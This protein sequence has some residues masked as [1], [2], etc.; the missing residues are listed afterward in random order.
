MPGSG[1]HSGKPA[2]VLP[3]VS[4]HENAVSIELA[5]IGVIV[6]LL[7]SG[8]RTQSPSN[9]PV[10]YELGIATTREMLSTR[11]HI[12]AFQRGSAHGGPGWLPDECLLLG[13]S[14]FA[15]SVPRLGLPVRTGSAGIGIRR[16]RPPAGLASCGSEAKC[17]PV[18]SAARPPTR[19]AGGRLLPELERARQACVAMASR[20][21][22][23]SEPS[24]DRACAGTW[25][26]LEHSAGRNGK[27]RT[28]LEGSPSSAFQ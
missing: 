1:V 3:H 23:V 11:G 25:S 7:L 8:T 10:K 21:L 14:R 26:L 24:T 22:R 27:S 16:Q 20:S 19:P 28:D 5:R 2:G 15:L 9:R 17:H 13:A 6:R 18:S 12:S 4:A